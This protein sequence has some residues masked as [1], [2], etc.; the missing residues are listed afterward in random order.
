MPLLRLLLKDDHGIANVL[1]VLARLALAATDSAVGATQAARLLGASIH[2][3]AENDRRLSIPEQNERAAL[4]T[5]LAEHLSVAE[6]DT[7]ITR[8]SQVAWQSL[9]CDH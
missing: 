4:L 1:F 9:P 6:C 5:A 3:R 8:G 2:L 7:L